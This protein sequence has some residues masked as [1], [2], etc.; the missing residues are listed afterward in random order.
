MCIGR[1]RVTPKVTSTSTSTSTSRSTP[2]RDSAI[3]KT[4]TKVVLS[5]DRTMGTPKEKKRKQSFDKVTG[6]KQARAI[7]PKRLG[8]RSLQIP[9]LIDSNAFGNLNYS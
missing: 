7:A 9:L 1:R 5:D 4:A 3:E 2:P 8:T 6:G